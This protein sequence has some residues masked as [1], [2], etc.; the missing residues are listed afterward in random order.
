MTRTRLMIGTAIAS[1]LL[2][3]CGVP[4]SDSA[5]SI[6]DH[7]VP[8]HLLSPTTSSTTTTQPAA[9]YVSEPIYLARDTK[10]VE[11]H[12]DVVVP[13]GLTDVLSAL[14]AG[15][16]ASETSQGLTT[17][18]PASLKVLD[19]TTEGSRVTLDLSADFGQITGEAETTA[20]A[21][22]VLTA[23]SQ[24]GVTDVLFSIVGRPISVPTPSGVTTSQPV[25]A[26]DYRPMVTP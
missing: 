23:T 1:A 26:A 2:A 13:A 6:P 21:Q 17:A 12:R 18:L 15:P 24:P 3:A 11:V 7:Q 20:V 8:F 16:T 10:I 14:F 22:L 25:T 19:T 4:T 9:A 5:R